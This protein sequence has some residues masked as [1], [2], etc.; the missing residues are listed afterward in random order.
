LGIHDFGD[1][2][3]ASFDAIG[4][5]NQCLKCDL[6]SPAQQIEL[7]AADFQRLEC[8]P[9]KEP[10]MLTAPPRL[11]RL[12]ALAAVALVLLQAPQWAAAQSTFPAYG[13]PVSLETARALIAAAKVEAV[14]NKWNMAIAVVDTS[15]ALVAMERMDN[16]LLVSAQLAVDKARSANGFKRPTK[17]LQDAVTS[18]FTPLLSLQG[19]TAVEGGVPIVQDGKLVGAIGV[20]GA[21]ANEDGLIAAAGLAVL[22]PAAR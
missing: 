7:I 16:T 6:S 3:V 19:T 8:K 2:R 22:K 9:R 4:A 11:A 21:N 12:G 13:A 5:L 20:S 10:T 15:G 1:G 14:K 17:A 18:G